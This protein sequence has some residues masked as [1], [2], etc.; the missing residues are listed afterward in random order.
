MK[1]LMVFVLLVASSVLSQ[2]QSNRDAR[3]AVVGGGPAGLSAAYRL[4]KAGYTNVTVLERA[5]EVGGKTE[6]IEYQG[7]NYEMGAI[8][9]GPSYT[10][11]IE[12]AKEMGEKIV[13]FAPGGASVVVADPMSAELKSMTV[14]A[15]LKFLA[16]AVEYHV[17]YFKYRRYF[18][19]PG[20]SLVPAELNEPFSTWVV[21]NVHFHKELQELLSHSFV[22]FGYGYMS[23]IPAAYVMRYFS[24]RLLRSFI[25]GQVRM[26]QDGYQ[27]LWKKIASNLK[28][29]TDFEVAEARRTNGVWSVKSKSGKQQE[30][31]SIIW[32]AP[33]DAA[34]RA[35]D[36]PPQLKDVFSKIDYQFYNSSLVEVEGVPRGSGV[37][38]KNYDV[39]AQGGVVSWLHR[40][41][42]QTG[43]ANFYTLSDTFMPPENVEEG[44]RAF[45]ASHGFKIKTVVKSVG[46]KYFPHFQKAELD[47]RAYEL[48]EAE[49]GRNGLFFAGEIM[50]FSTVEHSAEYSRALIE[51]FF[52]NEGALST[53]LPSEYP[54][55]DA[56]RKLD[57]L[58]RR[59]LTTEY[60]KRPGYK[61]LKGSLLKELGGFL[62]SQ[63]SKAFNN[64]TDILGAGREKIIHKLGS[65]ALLHFEPKDAGY[66]DFDA[67]IRISNAV[68]G[69]GGTMYPSFS[70]KIPVDGE[71]R[72]INFIVGKSFDPQRIGNDF[73][74]K[75]DFNFFRDD[76]KYPFSNELPMEPKTGFGKAFK[77]VF[78][79][80]H[81]APN[82]IGVTEMT[83]VMTKP[84][85]RR[86][87]FRAPPAIRDL[88]PSDHYTD[89]REVMSKIPVGSVLFEVYESTGLGDPGRLVG[90][91]RTT[92]RFVA[93]KFGDENLYFRHEDRDVKRPHPEFSQPAGA[94]E[95]RRSGTIGTRAS[96]RSCDGVFAG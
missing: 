31:D 36:L 7:H 3:I 45:A 17:L 34:A 5:S 59:I 14:A 64:N 21:K 80:A 23:E 4:K 53:K 82:Y 18:D 68:D 58:W 49:Q 29:E 63:L 65:T 12:L 1:S 77:W 16:A 9:S 71:D 50:N 33:L 90:E 89:E 19:Q 27:S 94:R 11:V 70:I 67:L 24:P 6:T 42:D 20:M 60:S 41:P 43:V 8:M 95:P 76:S 57:V 37:V 87:I 47:E 86:F 52:T 84:A 88:M 39:K 75:P 46:W 35:V 26:L 51:R 55:L 28:V 10:E 85:P 73:N 44:L 92:T 83:K 54:R 2:A 79:R 25:F 96:V 38:T 78:D 61:D 72:S 15:K 81:L 13:P 74:G 32:S 40:W 93:S 66:K 62:P 22:S 91:L 30:F 48:I 56:K 69:S